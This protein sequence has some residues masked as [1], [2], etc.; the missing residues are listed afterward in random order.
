MRQKLMGFL[1]GV[2]CGAL[3]LAL[4]SG[5]FFGAGLTALAAGSTVQAEEPV[6]DG[7]GLTEDAGEAGSA[8]GGKSQ[9][10]A[11]GAENTA[12]GS[13]TSLPASAAAVAEGAADS[14]EEDDGLYCVI[15]V[16]VLLYGTLPDP[17]ENLV[18]ILEAEEESYPMPEGSVDGRYAIVTNGETHTR[19]RIEYTSVGTYTY[20]IYQLPGTDEDCEY[21]RTVY[22]LIVYVSN[23]IDE[24]GNYTGNLIVTAVLY[25]NGNENEK[26]DRVVFNNV[27]ETEESSGGDDGDD[28]ED[29]EDDEEPE[30]SE[31]EEI[32]DELEAAGEEAAMLHSEEGAAE[33]AGSRTGGSTGDDSMLALWVVLAACSAAAVIALL[34]YRRRMKAREEGQE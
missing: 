12:A 17:A 6:S 13:G 28:E 8:A 3:S 29:G 31:E 32:S 1:T 16:S 2:A 23:E 15:D 7:E 34:W 18:V 24:D 4:V 14:D 21:D 10:D 11:S 27:Y 33:E 19:I 9:A 25:V 22:T 5:S 30:E 20:T 26:V